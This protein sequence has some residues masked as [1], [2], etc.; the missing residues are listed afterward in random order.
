MEL[1]RYWHILKRRWLLIVIPVAVVLLFTIATYQAPPPFY[2]VGMH[3][4]VSQEPAS[5]VAN[6][7]EQRYYN[8][9][10]SEYIVNGLTDWVKGSEFATT[11]SAELAQQGWEIPAGVIQGS[12]A[13][14]NVRSKLEI[15]LNNPDPKALEAMMAAV[16][17]VVQ[18]QNA[19]ALPQLGGET[20]VVVPLSEPVINQISPGI[21]SQLDLPVRILVALIAGVGLALLVEYLDP[22]IRESHELKAIGLEILGEIPKK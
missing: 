10:T 5:A 4:L 12:L 17:V 16:T 20:A 3:Y 2:N 6:A 22:T 21:R 1:R 14:D 7:D 13:A 18:E 19:D 9:L 8:W 11:V 15:S